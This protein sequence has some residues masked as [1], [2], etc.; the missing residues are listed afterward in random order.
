MESSEERA[1]TASAAAAA[2]HAAEVD[3]LNAE[4]AAAMQRLS[5]ELS[6]AREGAAAAQKRAEEQLAAAR[7]DTEAA[8]AAAAAEKEAALAAE[9]TAKQAMAVS[10]EVAVLQ[11]A[12]ENARLKHAH[13]E[14]RALQGHIH[15]FCILR[16][17]VISFLETK[18]ARSRDTADVSF[19]LT[20]LSARR[21]SWR[22]PA[23]ARLRSGRP[24]LRRAR[25]RSRRC[26]T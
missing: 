17:P 3:R 13:Q 9:A 12:Q 23:S 8:L 15:P 1:A 16:L 22:L 2:A 18:S 21:R 24:C 14:A 7:R 4:H 26:G 6:A 10:S 11:M 25:T 20:P 5:E 19:P